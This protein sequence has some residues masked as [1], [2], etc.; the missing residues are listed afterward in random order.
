MVGRSLTTCGGGLPRRRNSPSPPRVADCDRRMRR[1]SPVATM[2][3]SCPTSLERSAAPNLRISPPSVPESPVVT[4]GQ[5]FGTGLVPAGHSIPSCGGAQLN[6]R[7]CT[8]SLAAMALRTTERGCSCSGCS[9]PGG[10]GEL[11]RIPP[12]R[13]GIRSRC[14]QLPAP[15]P[16]ARGRT[17]RHCSS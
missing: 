17:T 8:A 14:W 7:Q 3:K 2:S 16:A 12:L 5:R 9:W 4:T 1:D 13:R 6:G 15:T 10:K 11:P